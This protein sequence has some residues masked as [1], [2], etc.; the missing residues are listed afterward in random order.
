MLK[1]EIS[2]E[3]LFP[4][5]EKDVERILENHKECGAPSR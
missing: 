4:L 5:N 1:R 3:R 2:S